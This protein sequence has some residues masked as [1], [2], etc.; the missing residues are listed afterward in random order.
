MTVM[1]IISVN[2]LFDGLS[3]G[4]TLC[5]HLRPSS[6]RE[7]SPNSPNLFSPVIMIT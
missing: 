2:L 6:G 4:F 7:S 1:Y 5:R 3:G